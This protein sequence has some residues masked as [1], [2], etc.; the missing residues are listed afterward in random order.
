MYPDGGIVSSYIPFCDPLKSYYQARFRVY[1]HVSPV[2]PADESELFDMAHVFAGGHVE[3]TSDQH[4]GFGANLIFPGRGINMG[5]GWETKRSRQKGHK[6]WVIIK[7]CASFR[8]HL[9]FR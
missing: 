8:S 9:G 5:A 1:G 2:H 7:L 6:D 4:Y 3:F